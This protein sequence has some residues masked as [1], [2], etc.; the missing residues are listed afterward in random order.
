[1]SHGVTRYRGNPYGGF[2]NA[3]GGWIVDKNEMIFDVDSKAQIKLTM[4][5]RELLTFVFQLRE[6]E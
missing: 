6:S 2:G 1:M 5:L 3:A 4:K